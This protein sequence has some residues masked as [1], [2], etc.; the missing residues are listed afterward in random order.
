MG[1]EQKRCVSGTLSVTSLGRTQRR[2]ET[3]VL[4]L[5]RAVWADNRRLS[6]AG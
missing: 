4:E 5:R 1:V 3:Q 6:I 2:M